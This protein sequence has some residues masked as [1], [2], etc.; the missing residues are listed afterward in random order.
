MPASVERF[1]E[2][3]SLQGLGR[4]ISFFREGHV[5]RKKKKRV[6]GV[7]GGEWGYFGPKMRS[8]LL[9]SFVGKDH[10]GWGKVCAAQ[11]VETEE[12]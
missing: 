12:M 2:N 7:M 3:A 10:I 11:G 1:L 8:S 9:I 4:E 5:P 6:E